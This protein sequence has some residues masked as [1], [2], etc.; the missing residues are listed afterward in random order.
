[1]TTL[2]AILYTSVYAILCAWRD[3]EQIEN[4]D[5][6]HTYGLVSRVVAVAGFIV[7]LWFPTS[8]TGWYFA[9]LALVCGVWFWIVFDF[10]LNLS[11]GLKYDYLSDRGIDGLLAQMEVNPLLFKFL[12]L[13]SLVLLL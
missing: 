8:L 4:T 7:A 12:I 3:A 1:M 2:F 6:W 10:T 5:K 9:V 13:L 11:R